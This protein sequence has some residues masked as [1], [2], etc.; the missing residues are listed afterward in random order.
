MQKKGEWLL[1]T[2]VWHVTVS[3]SEEKRTALIFREENGGN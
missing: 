2:V 3:F 1:Q